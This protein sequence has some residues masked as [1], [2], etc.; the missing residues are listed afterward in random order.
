MRKTGHVLSACILLGMV[1]LLGGGGL[2][3]PDG[4]IEEC[5]AGYCGKEGMSHTAAEYRLYR[6]WD[7][8]VLIYFPVGL[9]AL[10]VLN[11]KYLTN[12]R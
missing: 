7:I 8:T 6:V 3:F 5:P 10:A 9:L 2:R 12:W 11:R 1:L 4:P